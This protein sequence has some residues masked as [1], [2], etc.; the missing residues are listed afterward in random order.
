[1]KLN[2]NI[3]AALNCEVKS[4]IDFYKLK[5]VRSRPFDYYAGSSYNTKLD[6]TFAVN[7][8]VSGLGTQ[9]MTTACG[10]L[11]GH[12]DHMNSIWLNL[13]SA[14]HKF[15][16]VNEI[17]RVHRAIDMQTGAS[18]YPS[19]TA[20]WSGLNK[21]LFTFGDTCVDY[22]E[23]AVVDMEGAAF[24]NTASRFSNR[25]LVQ[26]LKIISDN[27]DES[28]E[29]LNA[30]LI[31]ELVQE[32]MQSID[33]FIAALL[34]LQVQIVEPIN[35]V[36]INLD[37]INKFHFTVSQYQQYNELVSKLTS[38][39]LFNESDRL[40]VLES[41]S[42]VHVLKILKEKLQQSELSLATLLKVETS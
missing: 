9:N 39:K 38:L 27:E 13:G 14:G 8:L 10:W 12:I 15:L 21:P 7:V 32:N 28:V 20:K 5:K 34:V 40:Q 16:D 1:M 36:K 18:Y 23:D 4:V 42:M 26:S 22:P 17:V 41:S 24:F 2:I 29:R 11:A 35:G 25:E 19:M 33:K 37:I 3:L 30:K 31:A 6:K